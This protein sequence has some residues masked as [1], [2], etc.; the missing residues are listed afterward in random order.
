M[1][2]YHQHSWMILRSLENQTILGSR[3]ALLTYEK[4][5][6]DL[7]ACTWQSFKPERHLH[8][9]QIAPE[10]TQ[11]R[12]EL[13]VYRS[14]LTKKRV[15]WCAGCKQLQSFTLSWFAT[16][17]FSAFRHWEL[18]VGPGSSPGSHC[19]S[20]K[21]ITS[22]LSAFTSHLHFSGILFPYANGS[23]VPFV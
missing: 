17:P 13:M 7:S 6:P 20:W 8:S 12:P 5:H 11:L 19:C 3:K 16:N 10:W 9:G 2:K 23:A 14:V 22:H 21:L 1:L 4:V 18:I 15:H